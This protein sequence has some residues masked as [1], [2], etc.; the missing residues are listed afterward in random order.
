[1]KAAAHGSQVAISVADNGRGIDPAALPHIFGL[2]VRENWEGAGTGV[3]LHVVDQIVAK[4][5][6]RIEA[7]SRGKGTGST[8]TIFLPLL[9][10]PA[11]VR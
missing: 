8:F 7:S 6:G 10:E 5:G 3:G 11:D 2:F 9:P 4:H 1:V